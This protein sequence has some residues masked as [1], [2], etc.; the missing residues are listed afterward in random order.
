MKHILA[1]E[2][3]LYVANQEVSS[4]FYEV[5]FKTKPTLEVPGMTEFTISE[6]LKIGLMPNNGIAKI[7]TPTTVHPEKGNGIPRCELYFYVENIE[8]E[9]QNA[10]QAGAKIISGIEDRNWGDRVCYFADS[11][12]HIIAFAEKIQ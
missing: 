5:L 1:S 10:L 12:G 6:S 3:I 2:F 7:I 11:D 9:Y 8:L 4:R